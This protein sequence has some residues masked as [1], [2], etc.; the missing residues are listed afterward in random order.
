MVRRWNHQFF[1]RQIDSKGQGPYQRR[2]QGYDIMSDII[3]SVLI[4]AH[5]R[6]EFLKDAVIS[7]LNQSADRSSFEIIVIKNFNDAELDAFFRKH[8]II[9]LKMD[10]NSSIGEDILNGL[11]VA[12]GNII[13]FLDDDDMFSHNKLEK[14]NEIFFKYPRVSYYHNSSQHIDRAGHL[15]NS[16]HKDPA[17]PM[18]F[19]FPLKMRDIRR[20]IKLNG[21][22]NMSS[23]AVR[24]TILLDY[25]DTIKNIKCD[26]DFI[27]ALCVLDSGGSLW[28]DNRKLTYYRIHESISRQKFKDQGMLL[29]HLIRS[30]SFKIDTYQPMIFNFKGDLRRLVFIRSMEALILSKTFCFQNIK[31]RKF[32]IL[33]F[34]GYSMK[35]GDFRS[36][37]YVAIY[38]L[39]FLGFSGLTFARFAIK[40]S[41]AGKRK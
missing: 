6:K 24:R 8:N 11:N 25:A 32:D 3:T 40:W 41:V 15:D 35:L 20:C 7:V 18:Y 14:V 27:I 9:T 4:T 5:N 26:P 2:H 36:L 31:L 16:Y 29:S 13:V 17:V 37:K 39:S 22:G 1:I 10:S 33:K 28:L 30:I 12:K 23:I 19:K 21:T 34:A 38:L